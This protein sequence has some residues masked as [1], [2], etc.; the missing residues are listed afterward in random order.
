[1]RR[2]EG[3]LPSMGG[4]RQGWRN[5]VIAPYGPARAFMVAQLKRLLDRE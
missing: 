2:F 1:L 5:K 4:P 3:K